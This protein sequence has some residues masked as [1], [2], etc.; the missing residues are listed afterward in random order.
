M[1]SAASVRSTF[2]IE[3]IYR[4]PYQKA[5]AA[6]A[7]MK[8][9]IGIADND[10]YPFP[11]ITD[12]DDH[13]AAFLDEFVLWTRDIIRR[14][15]LAAADEVEVERL[16]PILGPWRFG[17]KDATGDVSLNTPDQWKAAMGSHQGRLTINL[18]G[19]IPLA[20]ENVRL[21]GVGLSAAW[22]D[23]ALNDFSGPNHSWSAV[24][25]LPAQEDPYGT[26]EYVQRA[27]VVLGRIPVMKAAYPPPIN[28]GEEV[29]NADPFRDVWTVLVEPAVIHSWSATIDRPLLT[30]GFNDLFLHLRLVG[31]PKKSS[32][33]WEK[34]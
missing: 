28:S 6:R 10:D 22:S 26:G 27:P 15:E 30:R 11:T 14:F 33:D 17:D 8:S 1:L 29:W 3:D 24:I 32:A 34:W 21:R 7:G 23:T 25:F 31:R 9:Q 20:L 16:I 19:A 12:V 18:K 13:D 2:I 5:C 4:K